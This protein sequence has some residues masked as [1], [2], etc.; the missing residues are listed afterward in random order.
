MFMKKIYL[1]FV[2]A[3]LAAC[4]AEPVETEGI[5]SLD[6]SVTGK[7]KSELSTNV[8]DVRNEWTYT[9]KGEV[10]QGKVQI[11]NDCDSVTLQF[12]NLDGEPLTEVDF[13]ITTV[14]P[15]LSNGGNISGSFNYD[16]SD[17]DENLS[18]TIPFTE[19]GITHEDN[20]FIFAKAWGK[21][22]GLSTHG[23][24]NYFTYDVQ[25]VICG[26]EESF[27]YDPKG[28]GSYTFTYIPAEDMDDAELVFTFP[29]SVIMEGLTGWTH[30]GN[31]NA[32]TWKT[33]MDL[34]ACSTYSWTVTLDAECNP[35][36]KTILWTD[37][38]VGEDSKK[39][40]FALENIVKSCS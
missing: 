31:G 34:D 29:Q 40:A 3:A 9:N 13:D 7:T 15:S 8:V 2:A 21:W 39:E 20:L 6:A 37:F 19:L 24:Y 17:L 14:L 25:E 10:N 18:I 12:L 4:S 28:D 27:I 30:N 38:N 23:N 1:L 5:D 33:V 16:F 11:I 35:S 36:G 22:A 26:C 32:Q